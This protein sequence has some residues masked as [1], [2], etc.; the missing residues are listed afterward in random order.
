MVRRASLSAV[1]PVYNSAT[2]LPELVARLEPVLRASADEFEV[3]FVNDGSRDDSWRVL[4]QLCRAHGWIRAITL[5]R[6]SGQHNALLCGIRVARHS[7][8]VTLD[9]DLQ[10]PPEEIPKLLE[11]LDERVDVVYGAPPLGVHGRW[12]N[13][14]SQT[15]K[16]ALQGVLGA[17]TAR[18]VGPF[19]VFRTE[20]RKAFDQYSG[21]FVNIDVLLTWGTTRFTAIHVRHDVRRSGVSNYTFRMLLTH[22]LNMLTGFTTAPLQWASVLGFVVT[23]FGMVLLAYV[24]ARYLFQ[25]ARVPGFGFLASVII[26]FSGAQLVTLGIM[27][28]YL[29]RIHSRLLDRPPYTVKSDDTLTDP[30]GA[31]ITGV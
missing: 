2:S 13:V 6:N 18:M 23:L 24:L 3:V 14:A 9:D 11:A 19:R 12:R 26:I 7:L 5:M 21:A 31:D 15:T 16:I 20:L 25:G 22:S 30:E 17:E 28:E 10:N 27:G 29:A 1:V 4:D 8:I